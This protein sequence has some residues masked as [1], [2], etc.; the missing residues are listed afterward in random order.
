MIYMAVPD[1]KPDFALVIAATRGLEREEVRRRARGLVLG[2]LAEY[3]HLRGMAISDL[4]AG[5]TF[6][7][8]Y[9]QAADAAEV[10]RLGGEAGRALFGKLRLEAFEA[11]PLPREGWR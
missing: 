3:G 5:R 4:D 6:E 8:V 2:A 9:M 7:F 10:Q 1:A 11:G